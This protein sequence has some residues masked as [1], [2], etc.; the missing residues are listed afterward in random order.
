VSEQKQES[1]GTVDVAALVKA[2]VAEA[3]GPIVAELKAKA[4]SNMSGAP[5][6]ES[7]AGEGAE[8]GTFSVGKDASEGQKGLNFVREL[9]AKHFARTR[10]VSPA[11]A[12]KSMGYGTV[13][14][15]LNQT[16]AAQGGD[17]V[18]PEFASEV[19]EMLRPRSAVRAAGAR[20]VPMSTSTLSIP[21]QTGAGSASYVGESVNIPTSQQTVGRITL[22][23]KKLV[24]L[25]AITNDLLMNSS[26]QADEFVRDDLVTVMAL[27]EDLAFLRGDGAGNTPTG[28]LNRIAAG[29]KFN[30]TAA[31]LATPT[32][33]ELRRELNKVI[34]K[35]QLANVPLIDCAWILH[36]RT[37]LYLR[38]VQ[39]GNGNAVF[40]AQL[41]AGKLLGFPV[42][43]TTQV[44]VNLTVGADSDC[45]EVYFGSF[46][47]A[48]IG[49]RMSIQAEI[50]SNAAYHNGTAV[51]AG[52][53][54]DESVV[55]TI[56]KHDFNVRHDLAFSVMSGV[57]MQ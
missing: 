40:A 3:V 22:S 25:T 53:S 38:T 26:I 41:E 8:G 42:F 33:A 23:E 55:R 18:V 5:G 10:G 16:T 4:T 11:A 37:E 21:K 17:T 27:R 56:S 30:M 14:K 20:V 51:V 36:P 44:P 46:R 6:I 28:L 12:A 54:T 29:N 19:I 47:H 1:A 32:L 7:P 57:R 34:G 49:D 48:L 45:S 39:D 52:I 24:A 2:A 50:F 9:K 35:L 31:A 15:A 13:A 43:L